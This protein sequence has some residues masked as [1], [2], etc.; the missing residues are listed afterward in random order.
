MIFSNEIKYRRDE[1]TGR[2]I[3]E[4]EHLRLIQIFNSMKSLIY[5]CA[6]KDKKVQTELLYSLS[7]QIILRVEM[8]TT[9]SNYMAVDLGLNPEGIA[10]NSMFALSITDPN[11]VESLLAEVLQAG[12]AAQSPQLLLKFPMIVSHL[13][14]LP[15]GWVGNGTLFPIHFS[16]PVSLLPLPRFLLSASNHSLS[17]RQCPVVN[18]FPI[19]AIHE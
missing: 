15:V 14:C 17:D 11:A 5:R 12:V 19:P 8:M 18:W 3:W 1:E 7:D 2:L 13:E 10:K 4:D 9:A 6:N 16:P